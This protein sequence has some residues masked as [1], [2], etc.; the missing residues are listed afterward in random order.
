VVV[1]AFVVVDFGFVV[2]VDFGF[3]VVVD[4]IMEDVKRQKVELPIEESK[5]VLTYNAENY[6]EQ[7]KAAIEYR[8]EGM[9]VELV[10]ER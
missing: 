3:V 5:K 8:K 6:K 4:D 10:P 1:V 9:A 7:L 2:V